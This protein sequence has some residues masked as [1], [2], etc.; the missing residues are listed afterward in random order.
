MGNLFKHRIQFEYF[1]FLIRKHRRYLFIMTLLMIVMNPFMIITFNA[2]SAINATTLLTGQLFI[3]SIALITAFI[4]PMMLFSFL[5]NKQSLDVFLALPIKKKDLYITLYSTGVFMILFPFFVGWSSGLI[6]NLMTG[7]HVGRTLGYFLISLLPLLAVYS[8]VLYVILNTGN[9]WN[10][11]LYSVFLQFLPIFVYCALFFFWDSTFLGFK[12]QLDWITIAMLSPIANLFYNYLRLDTPFIL[13]FYWFVITLV[14]YFINK[15]FFLHRKVEHAGKSF[16]NSFFFPL[17]NGI[18]VV[19]LH[20]IVYAMVLH[21]YPSDSLFS[22]RTLGFPF[23][24]S[25]I[26]YILLDIITRRHFR[27]LLSATLNYLITGALLFALLLPLQL[28]NGLG[29]ITRIPTNPDSMTVVITDPANIVLSNQYSLSIKIEDAEDIEKFQAL[30][31][32]I[33]D[34]MKEYQYSEV[35]LMQALNNDPKEVVSTYPWFDIRSDEWVQITFHYEYSN[36]ELTRTYVI[37]YQWTYPLIELQDTKS[38]FTSFYSYL[39]ERGAITVTLYDAFQS[40]AVNITKKI[41]SAELKD[42]LGKD[43]KNQSFMNRMNPSYQLLGY[44]QYQY[45]NT[46]SDTLNRL[47]SCIQKMIPIT[48]D[49]VTLLNEFNN[50]NISI[51]AVEPMDKA[52]LIYPD[53]TESRRSYFH[54]LNHFGGMST[55]LEIAQD[56]DNEDNFVIHYTY[57]SARQQLLIKDYLVPAGISNDPTALVVLGNEELYDSDTLVFMVRPDYLE[58]VLNLIAGNEVYIAETIEDLYNTENK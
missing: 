38:Y 4:I 20:L 55:L 43:F 30:H 7:I 39:D 35:L 53:S 14:M 13:H 47:N 26:V 36:K 44:I 1:H 42:L 51:P 19:S 50:E 54:Y 46:S 3:T 45:C 24:F 57:L 29:F 11:L 34:A 6:I 17:M 15:A 49:N 9:V 23:V 5:S 37:P 48:T 56:L 16:T 8:F 31:Q 2:S 52:I 33:L 21:S 27:N 40:E 25:L 32:F 10:T 28:T 22:L 41:S 18:T 12:F 58:V